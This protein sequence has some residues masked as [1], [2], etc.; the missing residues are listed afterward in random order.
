MQRAQRIA[1]SVIKTDREI[2]RYRK[3]KLVQKKHAPPTDEAGSLILVGGW[4]M[5]VVALSFVCILALGA[6]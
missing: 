2:R 4:L 6:G 5:A 1:A 3:T